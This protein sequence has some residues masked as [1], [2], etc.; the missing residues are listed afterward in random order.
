MFLK[1]LASCICAEP[2]FSDDDVRRQ[3]VSSVLSS[4]IAKLSLNANPVPEKAN[5]NLVAVK[6]YLETCLDLSPGILGLLLDKLCDTSSLSPA[7]KLTHVEE[8]LMPVLASCMKSL[9]EP[10]TRA[11]IVKFM[12]AIVDEYAS[13]IKT[14]PSSLQTTFFV[15]LLGYIHIV[16]NAMSI[17]T[18]RYVYSC[19]ISP[20]N[21]DTL[22]CQDL[23]LLRRS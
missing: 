13:G 12:G 1:D 9:R 23:S 15:R 11:D 6:P 4:A 16:P 7:D 19:L 21:A 22:G 18:E 2:S 17:L 5:P 3:A 10:S 14:S 8:V 20:A